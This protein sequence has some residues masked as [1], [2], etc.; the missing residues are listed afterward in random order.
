MQYLGDKSP[1]AT[2]TLWFT[3]ADSD[4][5]PTALSSGAISVYKDNS[6]TESTSGVTLTASADSR[7]GANRVVIDT[8]ADGS[9][10]SAGSDFT[11]MITTGT[12]DSVSVVGYVVGRFSL[13]ESAA[14]DAVAAL[15]DLSAAEVN[16]EV[17]DAL[18]TDTYAEPGQETPGATISLAAKIGY[19]FKAWRNRTTQTS[20]TYSLYNDDGTTVGQTA[21][22][23]DNG[24]TFDRGEVT[25]GS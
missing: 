3:T 23:A 15:N 14:Y 11:V 2:I 9:F 24:T 12:V 13:R 18:S 8:S 16:A 22:V 19:L 10:Y 25:T 1:G 6:N 7:T 20:D 4:G 21:T 5:A 17:V